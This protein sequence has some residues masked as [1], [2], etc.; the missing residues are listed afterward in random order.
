MGP[1]L[2]IFV[3]GEGFEPTFPG[4]GPVVLPL[5]EPPIKTAFIPITDG[6][7]TRRPTH[8]RQILPDELEP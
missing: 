2:S 8:T 6:F 5:D 4:S 3:S 1:S 7:Q